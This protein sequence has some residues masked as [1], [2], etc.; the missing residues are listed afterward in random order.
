MEK[1]DSD[2][3][4]GLDE[5]QR[6]RRDRMRDSLQEARELI[7]ERKAACGYWRFP[8]DFGNPSPSMASWIIS[9][10]PL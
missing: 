6:Q 9:L 3:G 10:E 2:S 7:A 4:L 8:Y 1:L 5:F